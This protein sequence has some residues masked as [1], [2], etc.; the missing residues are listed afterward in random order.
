[1]KEKEKEEERVRWVTGWTSFFSICSFVIF[2]IWLRKDIRRFDG[3]MGFV[4]FSF[5]GR[6]EKRKEKEVGTSWVP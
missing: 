5:A 3:I 4:G 6:N 2:D 1:M